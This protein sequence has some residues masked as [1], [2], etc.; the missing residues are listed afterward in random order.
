[1]SGG[2]SNDTYE[3]KTDSWAFI[4]DSGGGKDTISF[5]RKSPFNP[6]F[7]YDDIIVSTVLINNLEVLLSAT[8]LSGGGQANGIDFGDPFGK[9]N[10]ANTL[11]KY[12]L[13]TKPIASRSSTN[14]SKGQ[15]QQ[16]RM[17]Q[18]F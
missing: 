11:E 2:A 14:A 6:K 15:R 17:V 18:Q 13:A 1:M 5:S 8:S 7:W 9:F 16:K 4:A 10:E 3:F 12:D